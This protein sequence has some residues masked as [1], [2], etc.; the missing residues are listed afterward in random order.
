MKRFLVSSLF[1]LVIFAAVRAHA[2]SWSNGQFLIDYRSDVYYQDI[3]GNEE[4]SFLKEGTHF[5]QELTGDLTQEVA[6]GKINLNAYFNLRSSDDPQ[7]QIGERDV[8]FVQ[9]HIRL[10][11]GAYELQG[12]DFSEN[13]TPYTLGASLLG[14]KAW[15]KPFEGL[16][17]YALW[18]RNRDEELDHYVRHTLGGRVEFSHKGLTLGATFVQN[19]VE[20]DSLGDESPIGD[21]FNQ[22]YGGGLKLRLLDDKIQLEAEYARSLYN[23]DKRD[24]TLE[25]E[26]DDAFFVKLQLKPL[27]RLNLE[28]E[29]ERVEP[30]FHTVMGSASADIQRVKGQA[31]L[32]PWDFLSLT[33]LHEYSFDKLND[34][35]VA[36][37]RTHTHMTSFGLTFAPFYKREDAWNTFTFSLQV[38]YTDYY[39]EDHVDQEDLRI[40]PSISQSFTHWNYSISYA[41]SRNWNHIDRSSECE[42]HA[43]ALSVG[44][45]HQWLSLQWNWSFNLGFEYRK[46]LLEGHVDKVYR[47]DGSLTLNYSKTQS[48]LALSLGVKHYDNSDYLGTADNTRL[49]FSLAFDQVLKRSDKFTAAISLTSSYSDYDEDSPDADYAEAVHSLSLKLNF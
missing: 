3:Y 31:E 28:G 49:S 38:D 37:Y 47:A 2:F 48:S 17:V 21:E 33:L 5:L 7:H 41:F 6:P 9:G 39:A 20:R 40:S 35:S 13:F 27:G 23:P 43:P 8:M 36:D 18:G 29:F 32:T 19:D 1:L 12:G 11:N 30:L 24:N 22:V 42:S 15:V 44:I 45:N 34:D 25:D 16:K 26:Y 46:A 4:R 10:Y 14:T